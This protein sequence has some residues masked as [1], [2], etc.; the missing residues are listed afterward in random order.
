MGLSF[1][2]PIDV[3]MEVADQLKS[4]GRVSRGWLGVLIQDVTSELAESFNMD[5][6]HGALVAR[7]LPNSP[8]S[9]AGVAVGDIILKYNGVV[10]N[11]S[12]ELPPLVGRSRIDKPAEMEILR[13]GRT[14]KLDVNIGELPGD[15]EMNLADRAS[16]RVSENRLGLMVSEI[17]RQQREA[18]GLNRQGGVMVDSATG[19]AAREA[20]IQQGDVILMLN[21]TNIDGVEQ[22]NQLVKKLPAD[23]TVAVL[24]H[25][26][27]G[28]I[29]LALR[30]PEK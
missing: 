9:R 27:N 30:V 15:D 29:F 11:S 28:P 16:P 25:R 4:R 8:S 22:F 24:V 2:I 21:N 14:I 5:R 17:N 19:S 18:L 20:G 23:K 1:A 13:N 6:P 26:K 12:S 3:A 7:V 10:L